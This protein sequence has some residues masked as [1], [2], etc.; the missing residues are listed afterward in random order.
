MT[1]K[2]WQYVALVLDFVLVCRGAV[3]VA[4]VIANEREEK[5]DSEN[6]PEHASDREDDCR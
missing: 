3:G 1:W 6:E 4:V 5:V 2:R